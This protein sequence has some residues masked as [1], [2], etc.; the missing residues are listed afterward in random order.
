MSKLSY[1]PFGEVAIFPDRNFSRLDGVLFPNEQNF[2]D[3]V[4][5]LVPGWDEVLSVAA[6]TPIED[7]DREE[8]RK[9]MAELIASQKEIANDVTVRIFG[10]KVTVSAADRFM[11]ATELYTPNGDLNLNYTLFAGHRR[12]AAYIV[13]YC[14]QKKLQALLSKE[15]IAEHNAVIIPLG[16][17]PCSVASDLDE[18]SL[19]EATLRENGLKK[20]GVCAPTQGQQLLGA[21]PLYI[22]GANMTKFRQVFGV[23]VGTSQKMHRICQ[24]HQMHPT[25]EIVRKAAESV[26]LWN[27][28]DKEV[29]KDFIDDGAAVETVAKFV[30]NPPK[31]TNKPKTMSRTKIEGYAKQCGVKVVRDVCQAILNNDENGMNKAITS[32]IKKS[33]KAGLVKKS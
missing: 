8:A 9:V 29:I 10:K 14:A 6:V 33:E 28:L 20:E 32:E 5:L 13:A 19:M 27:A 12:F 1:I 23:K 26:E 25:L 11:A 15:D 24:L 3:L 2:A 17:V 31:G 16:D 21:L 18:V 7:K 30:N 22:L 4:R